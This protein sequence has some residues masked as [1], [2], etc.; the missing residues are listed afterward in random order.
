[1]QGI[2]GKGLVAVKKLSRTFDMHE[3]KFHKEVECLMK[4]KHKNIVHFLG[5]C[6]E[7]HGITADYDGKFVMADIRNWLLCFEY[8]PNGSLDQYITGMIVT[9][10]PIFIF[11]IIVI[12]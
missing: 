11:F 5:Y 3:I 4:A 7:T 10:A 6:S 2:V 12:R 1:M 8:V 9:F